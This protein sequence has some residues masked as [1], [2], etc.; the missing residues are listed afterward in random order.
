MAPQRCSDLDNLGPAE[1]YFRTT[2]NAFPNEVTTEWA[3]R[4]AR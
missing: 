1:V 3:P 4:A 2:H